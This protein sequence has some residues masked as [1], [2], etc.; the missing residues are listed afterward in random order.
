MFSQSLDKYHDAG[1]LLL[2]VGIGFMFIMHGMPK[3][4]GGPEL[5]EALGKS[6]GMFGIHFLPA[7]W[8]FMAALAESLG[9]LFLILGLYTRSASFFLMLTMVVAAAKHIL[10]GDGL[11]G[12]SHALEAGIVFLS[13]ILIGPGRLSIDAKMKKS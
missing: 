5:W 9:G 13:L 11:S 2:R 12:S 4:A 3:F 7:V 6:M 8:G 10:G 1:L